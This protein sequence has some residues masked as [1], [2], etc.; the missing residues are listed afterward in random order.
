MNPVP[1]HLP[2]LVASLLAVVLLTVGLM[3]AGCGE[4]SSLPAAASNAD[5]AAADRVRS[6]RTFPVQAL[7]VAPRDLSRVIQL[8]AIVEPMRRIQLAARTD[9]VLTELLVEEGDQVEAGAVLA[10]I[11]VREHRAELARARARL[12]E[13]QSAYQ[14]MRRLRER[15]VVD[16]ASYEAARA[17]LGI[18]QAEVQ[19]WQARSDFG[20]LEAP[21][22]ATVVERHFEPGEAV[23]RHQPVFTL[24]DLQT[25]VIRLGVSELDVG[26]ID[27]TVPVEITVDAL[28]D[29]PPLTGTVRR[30]FPAAD[31]DSRLVTVEVQLADA[32]ARGVRPGYLARARLIVDRRPD[33]LAVPINSV[34]EAQETG[35]YVMVINGNSRL[36]RRA[37][38]AGVARGL[39]R[40]IV[41]GL[42]PGD[43]VVASNPMELREGSAVRIVGWAG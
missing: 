31:A 25:Q 26:G 29:G 5:A 33:V 2:R 9:G 1:I 19:L 27:R 14:R 6:E 22:A 10:R 35:A 40:E 20:V 17:G 3:T 8:S 38:D 21:L 16:V 11:D 15:E 32:A 4:A 7:N 41:A 43:R 30:I 39:W 28:G 37:V 24:A 34:A 18:A 23:G 42:E 13:Q 12:D 36:E